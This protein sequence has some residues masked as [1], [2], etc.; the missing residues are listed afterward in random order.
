MFKAK[1][2]KIYFSESE[3]KISLPENQ[4]YHEQNNIETNIKVIGEKNK[5][6]NFERHK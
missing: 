1:A 3:L 6:R 5:K 4:T 2:T